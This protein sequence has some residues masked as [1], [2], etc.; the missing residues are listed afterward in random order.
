MTG[1]SEAIDEVRQFEVV[2]LVL[3]IES[4]CDGKASQSGFIRRQWTSVICG[5]P[6][7]LMHPGLVHHIGRKPGSDVKTRVAAMGTVFVWS[8]S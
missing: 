7:S 5:S 4:Y 2:D 1:T 8:R 6:Q 3:R